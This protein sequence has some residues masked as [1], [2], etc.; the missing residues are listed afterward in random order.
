MYGG[1]GA[2]RADSSLGQLIG[3]PRR[4]DSAI[5]MSLRL[6]TDGVSL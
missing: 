6:G 1:F 3:I 5:A 2:L 4:T